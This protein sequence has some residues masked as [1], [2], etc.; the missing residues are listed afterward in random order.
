M[1]ISNVFFR[2][3]CNNPRRFF[4]LIVVVIFCFSVG[5]NLTQGVLAQN[6]LP[7]VLTPTTPAA[8]EKR[9][10]GLSLIK[11]GQLDSAIAAFQEAT[12]LNPK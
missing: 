11:Q 10:E 6:P 2:I 12:R 9:N 5:G 1:N 8:A 3:C 7:P 4:G